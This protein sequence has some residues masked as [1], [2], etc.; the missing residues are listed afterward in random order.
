MPIGM[1]GAYI[2]AAA[3]KAKLKQFQ[4]SLENA[5]E[6]GI[7][8]YD[9][10][11]LYGGS[12]F[13]Y[14]TFLKNVLRETIFIATKVVLH[15]SHTPEETA[16]WVRQSLHN[17][18]ERLGVERIDLF[19]IHDVPNLDQVLVEGGAIETLI[20]AREEGLISYFGLATR[21]H[22]LL[23]MA[24]S[25]GNF[26]TILTYADYTPS[27][28]TALPTIKYAESKDV[29]VINASPLG[30]GLYTGA[31]PRT[32]PNIHGEFRY[33]VRDAA[34]IYDLAQEYNTSSLAIAM[35]FP[36]RNPAINITLTGAASPEELRA[37]LNACLTPLPEGIGCM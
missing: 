26:D 17:S 13:R 22:D 3:D 30:Y 35:H 25:N 1:G 33:Q 37:T 7:R 15:P 27:C 23:E 34:R 12:E 28:Q 10:S 29:G 14:G 36:M 11:P 24:V 20:K 21:Y 6:N 4:L 31:D 19:Q 18:L 9:T 5:Y 8:Y 16:I 2:G 32:N